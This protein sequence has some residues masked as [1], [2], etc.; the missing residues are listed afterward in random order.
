MTSIILYVATDID[1]A[2]RQVRK[3]YPCAKRVKADEYHLPEDSV[4]RIV[5]TGRSIRGIRPSL[6]LI[7]DKFSDTDDDT[8]DYIMGNLA[9]RGI[10]VA[11]INGQ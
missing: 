8:Y 5:A 10:A 6:V 7:D 4:I 2:H 9:H 11:Q 3:Y 1:Y